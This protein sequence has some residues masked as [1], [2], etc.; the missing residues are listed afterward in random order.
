MAIIYQPKG[1]GTD[2][3]LKDGTILVSA[4][5]GS[6]SGQWLGSNYTIDTYV[7]NLPTTGT[8]DAKYSARFTGCP[9][10]IS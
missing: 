6:T 8:I 5:R 10:C 9:P 1:G 3:T 2:K 4:P 7:S